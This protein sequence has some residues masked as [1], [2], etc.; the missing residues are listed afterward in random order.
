MNS[1]RRTLSLAS[2]AASH[3]AFFKWNR[4]Q[5]NS[6][7]ACARI[8]GSAFSVGKDHHLF[9]F[10]SLPQNINVTFVHKLISFTE[11]Y[12]HSSSKT[13]KSELIDTIDTSVKCSTNCKL[14]VVALGID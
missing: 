10:F 7:G 5:L 4:R 14:V 13:Y 6:I 11:N 2:A 3:H 8:A 9:F 12:K 1:L